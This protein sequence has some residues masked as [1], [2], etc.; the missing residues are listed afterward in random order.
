MRRVLVP[1]ILLLVACRALTSFPVASP[2][3]LETSLP[4]PSSATAT[5]EAADVPNALPTSPV[6]LTPPQVEGDSQV[7]QLPAHVFTIAYHPDGPIFAGDLVS[8]EV[9]APAGQ[10]L[11]G[12]S[13]Q[14]EAPGAD[15]L[16]TSQAGFGRH[17]LAGRMQA[18]L[19]WAWDTV[20]LDSGVYDLALT[21]LPDGPSWTA[22]LQLQPEGQMPALESRAGWAVAQSEC[23]RVHYLTGT[24]AQRD[25]A[26]LLEMVDRQ[27]E[28]AARKL[29]RELAEPLEITLIPRVL[30]HGGFTRQ[31]VSVSYLD[32]NYAGSGTETVLHHE[33]IHTLDSELGGELR[34]TVLIEGLA[35]YLTGGHFKPEP[36]MPRAAALLPP[37][38]GCGGAGAQPCSLDWYIPLSTLVDHFYLEPHEVG[39]LQAGALVEYMVETWGWQSFTGF[40][41]DIHPVEVADGQPGS[42]YQAID[43]AVQ[44]HFEMSLPQL[45]A[46]FLAALGKQALEPENLEDVRLTVGYYDTVRRYQRELDPS[47]YFLTAWLPDNAQMRTRGITADY[48]RRPAQVENLA[49]EAMLVSADALLRGRDYP[50]AEAILKAANQVLSLYPVQGLA[51]FAVHPLGADY[52]A[53][54]QETLALGYQ[55]QR[56]QISG[57]TARISATNTYGPDVQ[58]GLHSSGPLMTELKLIRQ[59]EDWILMLTDS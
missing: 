34:P 30:G 11:S 58:D 44:A 9:I 22:S 6:L 25:L 42:Q 24:S 16:Q 26:D 8:L 14:L 45:E 31:D 51:A 52:L 3:P 28:S 35:V 48:L 20:G 56:I 7:P 54:V 36:L 5:A 21:V 17:G 4:L 59:G 27:M 57:Q 53:L 39:Y 12:Y 29:D 40:Y 49:L 32:R 37:V 55:P 10:D 43:Q 13:V 1:V 15:G 47:A 23:C 19:L 33:F 2:A 50:R 41:R 38:P 18:T 46:S